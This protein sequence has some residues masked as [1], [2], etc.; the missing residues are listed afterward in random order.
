MVAALGLGLGALTSQAADGFDRCALPISD[1][2]FN[3]TAG[4]TS[5]KPDDAGV[6][7][8]DGAPSAVLAWE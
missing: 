7:V 2:K 4:L 3:G 6:K 8:P 1:L 5:D